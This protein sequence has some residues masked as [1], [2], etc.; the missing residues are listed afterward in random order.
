M[1][2]GAATRTRFATATTLT[3]QPAGSDG[4]PT[5]PG[6]VTVGVTR[7]DGSAL[8]VAGAATVGTGTAVRAYTLTAAET[9]SLDVLTATWKVGTVTVGT[10]S[11]EI[12]GGYYFTSADLRDAEPSLANAAQDPLLKLIAARSEVE[13]FIEGVCGCAFVP[14][15]SLVRGF[16][17]DGSINYDGDSTITLHPYLRSIRWARYWGTDVVDYT[18][19]TGT[20]LAAISINDTGVISV[21]YGNHVY[22]IGY[23]HGAPMLPA[24]IKAA[25]MA[26]AR[27]AVHRK[28]SGIPDR[29]QSMSTPEGSTLNFGRVGTQWRPTG[30]EWVD[31]ILRRPDYNFR[32]AGTVL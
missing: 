22:E 7:S 11:H 15:F 14:R 5:D 12:V 20:E 23:E 10:T 17:R 16:V 19:L 29:V 21:P 24:D 3:F 28:R 6:V 1:L 18:V 13:A 26:I 9:A 27:M 30:V 8:V 32:L 31:E 4:E 25:A 2:A